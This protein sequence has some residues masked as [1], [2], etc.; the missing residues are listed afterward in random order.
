M[1]G[2]FPIGRKLGALLRDAGHEVV[3]A[4]P[5]TGVNSVADEGLAQALAGVQV[6]IDVSNT[7][8]FEAAAVLGR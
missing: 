5:N 7:P 2:R 3:A 6:V 1:G 4:S 8:S